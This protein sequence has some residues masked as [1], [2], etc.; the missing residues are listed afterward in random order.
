MPTL[1]SA[2]NVCVGRRTEPH[3]Y[4]CLVPWSTRLSRLCRF[5][6]IVPY[7]SAIYIA[8]LGITELHCPQ[9]LRIATGLVVGISNA[10]VL[11]RLTLNGREKILRSR[12]S[13][14]PRSTRTV[15]SISTSLWRK[16]WHNR[17]RSATLTG[18]WPSAYTHLSLYVLF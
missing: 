9:I 7:S 3:R 18:G 13:V 8:Y 15:D 2:T 10:K 5:D 4:P 16:L 1:A 6:T 12:L 14:L 11:G 17:E